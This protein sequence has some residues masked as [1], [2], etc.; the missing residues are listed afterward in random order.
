MKDK[1]GPDNR[2]PAIKMAMLPR[3]TNALGSIFGGHILSL[4][5]MAAGQHARSVSPKIFVTKVMREVEFIAP[6]FVGDIV[7]FYAETVSVGRTS[8]TIKVDV[9]AV[10]GTD[11]LKS[12]KVTSAEVVMVAVDENYN[13][14]P[15][16]G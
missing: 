14:I 6:V 3:D 4:I 7:S 13:P 2:V 11:L 15:I 16:Q 9:E 10:R 12:C 8:I 1:R 5:D